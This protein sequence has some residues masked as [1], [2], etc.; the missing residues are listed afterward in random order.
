MNFF[1]PMKDENAN[2]QITPFE[3]LIRNDISTINFY[4]DA[5]S[6]PILYKSVMTILR[7]KGILWE[8]EL[9]NFSTYDFLNFTEC[10]AG[11]FSRF[12]SCDFSKDEYKTLEVFYKT[13]RKR[14]VARLVSE[15]DFVM[16][17]VGGV[18]F[19]S[20][21]FFPQSTFVPQTTAR[22]RRRLSTARTPPLTLSLVRSSGKVREEAN[23]RCQTQEW[24][25][26]EVKE[27][28]GNKGRAVFAMKDFN[29]GDILCDYHAPMISQAEAEGIQTTTDPN[30]RRSESL[31]T[32][33]VDRGWAYWD[34]SAEKC[35]CHPETRIIGRLFNFGKKGTNQ[36]N[37]SPTLCVFGKK[38]AD[39]VILLVASRDISPLEEV[40]FDYGDKDCL[41]LFN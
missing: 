7:Y 12:F 31:S 19:A 35:A 38:K 21:K 37:A 20:S 34:G 36:C 17:E 4:D 23:I 41:S 28:W 14:W 33:K 9:N 30:D 40:C 15:P 39:T 18:Q 29:A 24:D 3:V 10:D 32:A 22:C 16:R 26:L 11:Y 27:S 25:G 13:A 8:E 2:D 1:S 6:D 5:E